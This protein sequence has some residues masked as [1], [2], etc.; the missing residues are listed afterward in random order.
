MPTKRFP[1]PSWL[2]VQLLGLILGHC[3]HSDAAA[4]TI[5]H[6]IAEN[7]ILRS[8]LHSKP[9]LTWPERL[10][11]SA[12]ARKLGYTRLKTICAIADPKTVI[13]WLKR[14]QNS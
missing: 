1:L 4:T 10:R 12:L 13:G 6:L 5:E 14:W 8:K 9:K 7:Q 2:R 3:D 11:L